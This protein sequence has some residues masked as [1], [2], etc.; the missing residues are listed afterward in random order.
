MADWEKLKKYLQ[1]ADKSGNNPV[2]F[3]HFIL[4]LM[5]VVEKESNNEAGI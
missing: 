5:D 1:D 2:V 4:Q 3:V